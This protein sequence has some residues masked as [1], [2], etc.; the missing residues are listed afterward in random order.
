MN[1]KQAK[2]KN[3]LAQFIKEREKE[4]QPPANSKRFNRAIKL[5]ASGKSKPTSETSS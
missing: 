1:L 5:I 2:T 3:K 4:K